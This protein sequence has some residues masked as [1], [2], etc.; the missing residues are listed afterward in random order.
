MTFKQKYGYNSPKYLGILNFF[1]DFLPQIFDRKFGYAPM[2]FNM[3][4]AYMEDHPDWIKE[5]RMYCIAAHRES[6]K[7]SIFGVGVPVYFACMNGDIYWEN[8]LLPPLKYH[9]IKGKTA[10]VARKTQNRIVEA[11]M[12]ETIINAFGNKVPTFKDIKDKMGK[13][14]S[15]ILITKDKNIFEALGIDQPIRGTNILNMRPH[16]VIYDDPESTINTK[17][18]ERRESNIRDLYN[19]TIGALDNEK[20]RL[21]FIGNIVHQDCILANLL[22]TENNGWKKQFYPLSY[23]NK[24]GEE[25][26]SWEKRFPMSAIKVKKEFYKNQPKL[27]GLKAFYMEYYN[28]IISDS[29]PIYKRNTNYYYTCIDGTNFI[30]KDG[31]YKNI[32]VSIGYDPAQSDKRGSSDTAILVLGTDAD[33]KKYIIDYTIGKLDLHDKY[34]EKYTP[35]YPFAIGKEDM[36]KIWKLGGIEETCRMAVKYNADAICVETASQQ[37]GIFNDIRE[38]MDK[39]T[40]DFLAARGYL[41]R[42]YKNIAM[43]P[44]TPRIDKIEKLNDSVIREFESGNYIEI[45]NKIELEESINKYPS[46]KLDILDAL[47]LADYISTPPIEIQ[48]DKLN[49]TMQK[50]RIFYKKY[51]CDEAWIVQ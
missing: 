26:S 37:R 16:N 11:L 30:Y 32:Y 22:R 36:S 18:E 33:K 44:Y 19:E 25:V 29:R 31:E 39:I 43:M 42:N 20:G 23:V 50:Q 13:N 2:H 34:E 10:E 21:V 46:A 27:G 38:R 17:T 4:K 14:N 6:A 1:F 3:L 15:R 28:T 5:N 40:P 45:I 41:G 8:Y 7:T 51:K 24:N 49:T 35:V 12:S 9:I 48:Y 47:F